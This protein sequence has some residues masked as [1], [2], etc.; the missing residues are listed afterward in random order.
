MPKIGL[1]VHGYLNTKEK[2]FC[3]CKSIH[4]A[5]FTK[6]N[7]NICPICTG[8]PGSKPMLANKEAVKKILQIALMLKSNVNKEFLWQRKHYDWP[9]LPKGFQTTISGSYAVPVA[10]GGEF[11]GVEITEMHLEEDPARW[12]PDTGEVDYSRAGLPLIEIVTEPDFTN[13]EQVVEWLRKLILTLAYIKALDKNAGIKVD[14]NVSSGGERVEIK[15]M[16]SIQSIKKAIEY[17]IKRQKI[18]EVTRKETRAWQEAK[19]VTVK[20][21]EK[22]E[23]EDYRFISEPNLPLIKIEDKWTKELKSALPES[24]QIKLDKIVTKHKIDKKNAQILTS[25]LELAEFFENVAE[26]I[27]AEFALSWVTIELLRVLNYNNKMLEEVDVRVEHFVE[28]LKLVKEKKITELKA[29]QMLNDFIPK[30]FMPKIGGK[31]RISDIEEIRKI[32]EGVL[33]KNKKAAEDYKLGKA[34]ALNFLLG[35]VMKISERRTDYRVVREQ[36]LELLK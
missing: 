22:E 14:V 10:S 21:R 36:M 6:P 16:N 32:C 20:M 24:P 25:N 17:E 5:K 29:K 31:G 27:D 18:E 2:L 23:A 7:I 4:G 34:E 28:L 1:E 15:N 33:Q 11:L 35:E 13:S 26:K 3:N 19:C 30:S 12:N 9:D 8:Y